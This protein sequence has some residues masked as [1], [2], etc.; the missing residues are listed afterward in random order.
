MVYP[1]QTRRIQFYLDHDIYLDHD[2]HLPRFKE[3]PR[4]GGDYP[5]IMTGGHARWSVHGVWRDNRLMNRLNRGQP[6]IMLGRIDADRRGIA[7]GDWV[8]CYNDVGSFEIRVKVA[9]GLR[10]GQAFMYHAFENYQFTNGTPRD[11]SPS[12]INPVELAGDHAHL[13][14]GMLEGQPNCF[15]RDTRI[16]IERLAGPTLRTG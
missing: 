9:S 12:P 15:D 3:P 13:R 6:Y 1:T 7:D 16:E 8:R 2:E 10:P 5:L 11:V 4:I 14:I